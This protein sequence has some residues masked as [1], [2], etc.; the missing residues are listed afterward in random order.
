MKDNCHVETTSISNLNIKISFVVALVCFFSPFEYKVDRLI[1]S[2]E[3]RNMHYRL[4]SHF[5]GS[6]SIGRQQGNG[7]E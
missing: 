6:F 2:M 1:S 7:D 5:E 3:E 4:E